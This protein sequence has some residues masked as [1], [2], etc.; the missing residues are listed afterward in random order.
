VIRLAVITESR[1]SWSSGSLAVRQHP[2]RRI[3]VSE[4]TR[5]GFMK[6]SAAAV[7]GFTVIGSVTADRAEAA[8]GPAGSEPVV[9]YLKN[10]ASGEITVMSGHREVTL[11]DKKLAG[12]IAQAIG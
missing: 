9:A 10:P 5:L 12:Q 3:P 8:T 11:R 2:R 7:A 4:I 1:L 6:S